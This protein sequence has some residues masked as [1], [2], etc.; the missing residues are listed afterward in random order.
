MRKF[1]RHLAVPF[2]T[3]FIAFPVYA[4]TFKYELNNVHSGNGVVTYPGLD[5]GQARSAIFTV[6]RD[7]LSPDV[8]L[9]SLEITFPTAAKLVA[10][11]FKRI[12]HDTYRAVVND[13]WIYRQIFIDVRGVDFNRPNFG[14]PMV[15]AF[16]SEKSV[17]V[18]PENDQTGEH[19]FMVHGPGLTDVTQ[20]RVAD[21]A[22]VIMAGKRLTLSLKNI[23]SY[24]PTNAPVNG[25]R[26]GFVVDALWM[27]KGQKT[28]YIPAPAPIEEFDSFEAIGIHI[29]EQAAPHGSEYAL[30]IKYKDRHGNEMLTPEL[31][32]TLFLQEAYGPQ[33]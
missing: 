9:T 29:N 32:L 5:F 1:T 14:A 31:P 23:L 24:A 25:S 17:F 27:G 8:Q 26:E 21:T 7:P 28:I 18:Q 30:V 20:S 6:N 12:D 3:T 10:T 2:I 22:S 33:L 19:L 4:K 11:G 15:E 16:I 13:Q